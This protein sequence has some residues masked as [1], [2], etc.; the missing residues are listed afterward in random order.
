MTELYIDDPLPFHLIINPIKGASMS[1]IIEFLT[2]KAAYLEVTSRYLSEGEPMEFYFCNK[3][4]ARL[5]IDDKNIRGRLTSRDSEPG[6]FEYAIHRV[7]GALDL[8]GEVEDPEFYFD[9]MIRVWVSNFPD[10]SDVCGGTP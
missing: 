1:D 8:L 2:K 4:G 6:E 7:M 5:T 10:H 3:N 9:G